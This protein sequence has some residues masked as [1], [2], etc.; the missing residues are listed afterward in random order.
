MQHAKRPEPGD[1]NFLGENCR[2]PEII[3]KRLHHSGF[4]TSF[5]TKI[6]DNVNFR[7]NFSI[8]ISDI[9]ERISLLSRIEKLTESA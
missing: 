2:N 1:C 6:G 5:V 7:T 9:G 4:Q 8:R 3:E